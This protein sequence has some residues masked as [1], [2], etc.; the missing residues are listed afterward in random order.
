MEAEKGGFMFYHKLERI[1]QNNPQIKIKENIEKLILESKHEEAINLG[2]NYLDSLNNNFKENSIFL[3]TLSKAYYE[4]RQF[5]KALEIIELIPAQSYDSD[6]ISLK[7]MIYIKLARYKHPIEVSS[8]GIKNF[9]LNQ[10]HYIMRGEA[11]KR[12]LNEEEAEKDFKIASENFS[13]SKEPKDPFEILDKAIESRLLMNYE[14]GIK[15]C[16]LLIEKAPN[17]NGGYVNLAVIYSL[18]HYSLNNKVDSPSNE[19]EFYQLAMD[20][21]DKALKLNPKDCLSFHYKGLLLESVG[22]VLDAISLY[23]TAIEFSAKFGSPI[24]ALAK[25]E[26]EINNKVL[27]QNSL[28][29]AYN[30]N[31][32]ASLSE[33]SKILDHADNQIFDETSSAK[34]PI[35][36]KK[37]ELLKEIKELIQAASDL[38][39]IIEPYAII[40]K[41]NNHITSESGVNN[42]SFNLDDSA[43]NI[44]SPVKIITVSP[45][46]LEDLSIVITPQLQPISFP[47]SRS[48]ESE[49]AKS[50]ILDSLIGEL[51]LDPSQ[52]YKISESNEIEDEPLSSRSICRTLIKAK[53]FITTTLE[54]AANKTARPEEIEVEITNLRAIVSETNQENIILR[55]KLHDLKYSMDNIK[56]EMHKILSLEADR[57][58]HQHN[59]GLIENNIILKQ[60]YSGF[61][62]AAQK[63][64]IGGLAAASGEVTASSVLGDAPLVFLPPFVYEG[65]TLFRAVGDYVLKIHKANKIT[66]ALNSLPDPLH[67]AQDLVPKIAAKIALSEGKADRINSAIEDHSKGITNKIF[68]YIEEFQDMI[69]VNQ[70]PTPAMKIGAGDAIKLIASMKAGLIEVGSLDDKELIKQV[71]S[72]FITEEYMEEFM[73]TNSEDYDD[74]I[75]TISSKGSV[76]ITHKEGEI[77]IVTDTKCPTKVISKNCE[78]CSDIKCSLSKTNKHNL[79]VQSTNKHWYDCI[80]EA[81][82]SCC[83]KDDI[84][85]YA[86]DP[87][88]TNEF[89]GEFGKD[90]PVTNTSSNTSSN[91]DIISSYGGEDLILGQA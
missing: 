87:A 8:D 81:I 72:I 1:D 7:S 57:L 71:L 25:L 43:T 11:Y 59:I 4:N 39:G 29:H 36:T 84:V 32:E 75:I 22:Q 13:D 86:V 82:F 66:T 2:Q 3:H 91:I 63:F 55:Q 19:G 51:N 24:F 9:P 17:F 38:K 65:I 54:L 49:A 35:E 6:F 30:G 69:W 89:A 10:N 61:L 90:T 67:F 64:C 14:D 58:D 76:K 46:D 77:F 44:T 37:L 78:T 34:K 50:E 60:Y 79:E 45:K 52:Q 41:I 56:S 5:D 18:Q 85:L 27:F 88:N 62:K 28:I 31:F 21:F 23:K 80:T 33:I 73:Q 20:S 40:S 48:S 74:N 53:S 70:N 42:L 68:S 12:L 83:R 16:K 15:Y 26:I 47:S